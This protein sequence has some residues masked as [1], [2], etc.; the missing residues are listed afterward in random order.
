MNILV[1]GATGFL[2]QTLL[3]YIFNDN[4]FKDSNIY[5]FVI[6]GDKFE[7]DIKKYENL[8]IVYGDIRNYEDTLKATR[9]IDIV[10]NCAGLI[11]YW[12]KDL[13]KLLD[14]NYK[15]VSNIVNSCII[16]NIKK[17][18]HISSVGAIGFF[19]DGTLADEN[20][21]YNYPKNLY[22]MYSKYLG[23]K[24]IEDNIKSNKI[25]AIILCPA[26]IMGPGDPDINTPHNQIYKR[27]YEGKF[28]GCFSG[29]LAVVDVRDIVKI[30]IKIIKNNYKNDK[31]LIVGKNLRYKEV[32]KTIEKYSGK[33]TYPFSITPFIL[34]F[35][36]S[37]LETISLITNKK[38]LL[39]KA[40]GRLSGWKAYY[41][42]KKSIETF[43]HSY[44]DFD[45]T[46]E[47]SC[48]YFEEKF[49]KN[50]F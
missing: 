38:P 8:K 32:I 3:S 26:S 49:L 33:K 41:S 35:A 43:N 20:T 27:V 2:G 30:I 23:Q 10:I 7:N 40:Y 39:T 13:P 25:N 31:Y 45:K 47:D 14:I 44:I 42:N 4:Y 29:G 6:P 21:P 22:Y 9:N 46:I 19:K 50:N 17:L 11:S 28:F 15:G 24:V 36:G 18:I 37:I 12:K 16:N 34:T 48:K 1:T 5:S